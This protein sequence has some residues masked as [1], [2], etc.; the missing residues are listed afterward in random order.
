MTWENIVTILFLGSGLIGFFVIIIA[1]GISIDKENKARENVKKS[2]SSVDE[3][4]YKPEKMCAT[5]IDM[6]CT[7]E[8]VGYRNPK[9]VRRFS[10]LFELDNSKQ[11]ELSVPEEYYEGFEIGQSGILTIVNHELYSF[12]LK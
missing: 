3:V 6:H 9:A 5:V 11:I 10:V 12:K 8:V 1:S 7:S 2:T 4:E